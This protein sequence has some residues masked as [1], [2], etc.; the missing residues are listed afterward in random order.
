MLASLPLIERE[1]ATGRLVCPISGPVLCGPDYVLVVN[2]DRA[3][4]DAVIAFKKWIMAT[5]AQ[6]P[7][8]PARSE[9]T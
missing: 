6:N 7:V 9:P 3:E 8:Q 5:A 1:I 4:D 2:R